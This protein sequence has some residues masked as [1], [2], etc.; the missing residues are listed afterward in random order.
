MRIRHGAGLAVG[1]IPHFIS[2]LSRLQSESAVVPSKERERDKHK[3]LGSTRAAHA[4]VRTSK[5]Q[6]AH[7]RMAIRQRDHGSASVSVQR[8]MT[9][10]SGDAA[11]RRRSIRVILPPH[12]PPL[13]RIHASYTSTQYPS[14]SS[15][16]L[17][18][19]LCITASSSLTWRRR[20][21]GQI[22]NVSR[23]QTERPS[24]DSGPAIAWHRKAKRAAGVTAAICDKQSRYAF[25]RLPLQVS[26][27]H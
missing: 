13:D 12:L 14:P 22:D 26:S 25:C 9:R 2:M 4:L 6:Q 3:M 23:S 8:A 5:Q 15:L 21:L 20:Q 1:A 19:F 7:Q 17:P 24:R 16:F 11:Q 10:C 27:R 18:L